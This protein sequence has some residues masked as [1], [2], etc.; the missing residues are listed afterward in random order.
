MRATAATQTAVATDD[1]SQ[2]I[3]SSD[4]DALPPW[5]ALVPQARPRTRRFGNPSPQKFQGLNTHLFPTCIRELFHCLI[6]KS[7]FGSIRLT[8]ILKN[9]SF[10]SHS[11]AELQIPSS[12]LYGPGKMP[13]YSK[14]LMQS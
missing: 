12:I 5:N 10:Y 7:Y 6:T 2:C 1:A 8:E 13:K 11:E 9:G 4:T 14:L 3:L